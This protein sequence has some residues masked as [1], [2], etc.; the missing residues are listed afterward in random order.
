MYIENRFV[1]LFKLTALTYIIISP[2]FTPPASGS[3]NGHELK[4][5][6]KSNIT[7]KRED[8]HPHTY[9]IRYLAD[10]NSDFGY[11]LYRKIASKHDNNIV[12][13]PFSVSTAFAWLSLGANGETKTQLL[14]GLNLHDFD[15]TQTFYLLPVL[16]QQIMENITRN[17]DLT[18]SQGNSLFLQKDVEV[19]ESFLNQSLL[20]FDADVENLDFKNNPESVNIINNYI[21]KKTDGEITD[22]LKTIDPQCQMILLNW[23]LFKGKWL[24][25]FDPSST[26]MEVFHL[27]KYS[28]VEV[29]MMFKTD[30]VLATYDQMLGCNILKLPYRG[31]A[32]MLIVVP[33]EG[34]DFGIVEDH[35]STNLVDTWLRNMK[36]RKME[37]Y[38][39]KFKLEQLYHM[40]KLL[41]ELNIKNIFAVGANLTGLSESGTLRVSKVMH[42]AFTEVDEKGTKA[43]AATVLHIVPFSLLRVFKVDRPFLFLIY[44]ESTRTL[45]FLGRVANPT[46]P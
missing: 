12:F 26:K 45:L 28:R 44:E 14:R 25:Q 33:G 40:S 43:V 32:S 4:L 7:K 18:L 22:I 9:T 37:I 46:K 21:S 30:D 24:E 3:L 29:P 39:P 1:F 41:Q 10:K 27:N 8:S 16:F 20:Y 38:I 5:H 35:L 2:I 23:V 11:N 6:H 31:K 15:D 34:S 17:D 42:K 13:S 36:M 19:K